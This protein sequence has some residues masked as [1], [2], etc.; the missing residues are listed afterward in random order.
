M[1]INKAFSNHKEVEALKNGLKRTYVLCHTIYKYY[2]YI[3]EIKN[4]LKDDRPEGAKELFEELE[5]PV[6][7]LLMTAPK[8]GGAFT[9]AE[10]A[11]MKTLWKVTV[12]DIERVQGSK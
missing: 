3:Y 8:F 5:Y 1:N 2:D 12:E 9:T 6:Q 7:K 4:Y 10:R 11:I